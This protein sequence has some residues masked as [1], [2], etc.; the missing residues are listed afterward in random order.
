MLCSESIRQGMYPCIILHILVPKGPQ[1]SLDEV[2]T[3]A[4]WDQ[5]ALM[6][7]APSN[8]P[9]IYRLCLPV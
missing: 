6:L 3:S 7:M 9:P 1:M 5:N 8:K 2:P 4:S